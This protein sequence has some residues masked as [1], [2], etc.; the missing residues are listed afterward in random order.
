MITVKK[1]PTTMCDFAPVLH[2]KERA[3]LGF[4]RGGFWF[5][6]LPFAGCLTLGRSFGLSGASCCCEGRMGWRMGKC[7]CDCQG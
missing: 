7:L 1:G 4:R 6:L 5:C 3:G 2:Q